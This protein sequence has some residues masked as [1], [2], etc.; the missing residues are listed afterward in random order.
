MASQA[1]RV[2][3]PRLNFAGAL[4]WH[5]AAVRP[6]RRIRALKTRGLLSGSESGRGFGSVFHHHTQGPGQSSGPF[7]CLKSPHHA[8]FWPPVLRVTISRNTRKRPLSRPEPSLFSV[9]PAGR[10]RWWSCK[11]NNLR[12]PVHRQPRPPVTTATRRRAS[13][14]LTL[15]QLI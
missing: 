5:P 7:S 14:V 15:R 2:S 4:T 12:A 11:I 9:W 8:G 13:L 1:C 6:N 3:S 10:R